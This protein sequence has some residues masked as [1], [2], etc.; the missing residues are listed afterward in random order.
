MTMSWLISTGLTNAALATLLALVALAISRLIRS[1]AL[2]HL[3]WIVVLIKLITPPII[4]IP[5]GLNLGFLSEHN[6]K[7]DQAS[8]STGQA[9]ASP[10]ISSSS[11]NALITRLRPE[12]VQ[13]TI[14]SSSSHGFL[15][16]RR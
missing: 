1:P 2:T 12:T 13:Q 4:P 6:A 10:L 3:L 14:A 5:V 16:A 9:V 11:P 8:D 7:A 15:T